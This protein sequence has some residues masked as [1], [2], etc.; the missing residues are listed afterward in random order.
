MAGPMY[1][2][3]LRGHLTEIKELLELIVAQNHAART[4]SGLDRLVEIKLMDP[5]Y[6]ERLDKVLKRLPENRYL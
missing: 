1:S 2:D 5:V 3:E 4:N 6:K